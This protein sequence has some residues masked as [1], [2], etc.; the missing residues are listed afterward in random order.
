MYNN[1]L[2]IIDIYN[3]HVESFFWIIL[4]HG[5]K[6]AQSCDKI[7]SF[8]HLE[9]FLSL[10]TLTFQNE[11]LTFWFLDEQVSYF[12]IF[13]ELWSLTLDFDQKIKVWLFSVQLT[14][15]Q[16]T[17]NQLSINWSWGM[18]WV[19]ALC[20]DDAIE[21]LRSCLKPTNHFLGQKS[22]IAPS[23]LKP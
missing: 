7:W 4:H 19:M 15:D 21:L 17:K 14:F 11:I 9:K 5:E 2:D 23:Q 6:L 12:D 22:E 8:Q 13:D 3:F 16:L 1:V 18:F 20:K 10:E